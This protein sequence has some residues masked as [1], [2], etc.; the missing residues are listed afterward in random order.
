M[1]SR[2]I[3][4]FF[5]IACFCALGASSAIAEDAANVAVPKFDPKDMVPLVNGPN[6]VDLDGDG[7]KD[8]VMKSRLEAGTAHDFSIY[9]FHFHNPD[10]NGVEHFNAWQVIPFIKPLDHKRPYGEYQLYTNEGADCVLSDIRLIVNRSKQHTKTY[11]IFAER[12]NTL[13]Y[14]EDENFTFYIYRLVREPEVRS[15]QI[16]LSFK[17]IKTISPTTK[18]CGSNEAFLAEF[19]LPNPD[20]DSESRR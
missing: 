10:G 18:Y 3:S 1:K 7:K 17:L 5:A 11:A 8:L 9:S 20:P 2:L 6:W 16:I 13:G 14:A 15:F 19:G 4:Q 12:E